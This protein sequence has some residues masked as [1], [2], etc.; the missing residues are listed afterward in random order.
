M[1]AFQ[2]YKTLG[3]TQIFKHKDISNT[4]NVVVWQPAT[5]LRIALTNLSVSSNLGGTIAIF[6]GGA[7]QS[8]L[9]EFYVGGSVTI[10]PVISCWESTATD[11]PLFVTT[12]SGGVNGWKVSAE[13]FELDQ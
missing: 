10:S 7:N 6:F 3:Q 13:G 1:S 11:A 5:S 8:K 4:G 12:S 2:Y 9:A